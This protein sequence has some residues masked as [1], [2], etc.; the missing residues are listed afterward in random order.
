M[1]DSGNSRFVLMHAVRLHCWVHTKECR[2]FTLLDWFDCIFAVTDGT[3]SEELTELSWFSST[4][5]DVF[6]LNSTS[7]QLIWVT[8]HNCFCLQLN[9]NSMESGISRVYI[10]LLC[11]C[12]PRNACTI[13]KWKHLGWAK[14]TNLGRNRHF[15]QKLFLT[16][17]C[18]NWLFAK[19]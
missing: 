19:N 16:F 3:S 12:W 9:V 17:Y 11:F 14:S 10:E 8:T 2:F 7:A 6:Q 1:E 18:R 5:S 4:H 13:Q 15:F